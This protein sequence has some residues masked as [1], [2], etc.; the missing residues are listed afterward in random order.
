[1]KLGKEFGMREYDLL[2]RNAEVVDGTGAPSFRGD[3]GIVDGR[4]AAVGSLAGRAA[5]RTLDVGGK[6]VAPGHITQHAHY[7]AAIFWSPQCL[8]SGPQGVTS[9]LNANCGFSMAPV[10]PA[11]RERTMAMLSTTEQ[12]PVEQQRAALPWDWETFPEFMARLR[13][14]PKSVNIM[15][16]LPLNPLLIYVMGID[17]AKSRQPNTTEIAEM[18]RLI[19]EAM[20]AGAIG[21]SASVMGAEG[22]TH[23]DFDGTS[24]PTDT[25]SRESI[26]A[27]ARG[28]IERGGGIVQFFANVGPNGDR[29]TSSD[30]ARAAKG[31]GVRVIHNILVTVEGHP[32]LV[33]ADLEW[34]DGMRGEGLDITGAT[35]IHYGWVEGGIRDLDTSAGD[36]AGVREMVACETD[37]ALLAL[38]AD[39]AFVNSFS[40]E[41][42]RDGPS[43]SAAGFEA[44]TLVDAGGAAELEPCL[45]RTLGDI[46]SDEGRTVVELLCDLAVRSG[47]QM[48]LKS[49]S[50]SAWDASL[51]A[52]MLSHPSIAAGVSDG[53]AHTK[54]MS[55]G[56]YGTEL[57]VRMGRE[58]KVMSVEELHFQLSFKV[59]RTLGIPDRGAILP[60]YWADLIV[61]DL[62]DLYVDYSKFDIVH[63]MPTGDWRREARA[64]GYSHIFVNGVETFTG[65]SWTKAT[66][67]RVITPLD[68]QLPMGIDA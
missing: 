58:Q 48:Q 19:N 1:M 21:I 30:V 11:D 29:E 18:H 56:F 12:I 8:D 40:D 55:N 33:E 6:I 57:L 62:A 61:Y 15:T 35:L 25:L 44:F 9:I 20:D 45:G 28:L 37:E 26:I 42:L 52:R 14:L 23:V 5:A 36:M 22:N 16:Y 24:M 65:S 63:D 43:N 27:I 32:A 46:A 64:G 59:A 49:A 34:I 51:P 39:P 53:G 50:F 47:L 13:A 54:S 66:P 4:I 38:L 68:E 17:A 67:G 7:D 3:I 41:Y 2:I 10:R 31:S 60:G